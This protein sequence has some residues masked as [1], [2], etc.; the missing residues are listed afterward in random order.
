MI[1]RVFILLA[2]TAAAALSGSG[3]SK[4]EKTPPVKIRR[5][6]PAL[7]GKI[8]CPYCRKDLQ[9]KE[10][11]A[12]KAPLSRCARCRKPAPTWKFYPDTGKRR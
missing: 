5:D 11:L 3:C 1:F 12:A 8:R 4:T 9:K 7:T 6:T 10:L 2:V